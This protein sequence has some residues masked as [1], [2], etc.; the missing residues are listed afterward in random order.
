[1]AAARYGEAIGAHARALAQ[2]R[3][4]PSKG[5][6]P[7]LTSQLF[8]PPRSICHSARSR[9]QCKNPFVLERT[10]LIRSLSAASRRD[11]SAFDPVPSRPVPS[12]SRF[13]RVYLPRGFV[14]TY[15]CKV[16]SFILL[17][18]LRSLNVLLHRR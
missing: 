17:I 16:L 15:A 13:K 6:N 1:V 7:N 3:R 14:C 5:P 18:V 11:F 8:Q 4:S 10:K 9:D 2:R 12:H